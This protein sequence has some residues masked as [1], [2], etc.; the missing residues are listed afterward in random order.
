MILIPNRVQQQLHRLQKVFQSKKQINFFKIKIIIHFLF[1][2]LFDSKASNSGDDPVPSSPPEN[3]AKNIAIQ[4]IPSQRVSAA[5]SRTNSHD[6]TTKP[7]RLHKVN[8]SLSY[9][10]FIR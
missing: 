7:G 9:T 3:R 2:P 4:G 1:R 6:S 5:V 8:L 10:S